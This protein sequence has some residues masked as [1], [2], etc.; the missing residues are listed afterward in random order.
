MDAFDAAWKKVKKKDQLARLKEQHAFMLTLMGVPRADMPK[1]SERKRPRSPASLHAALRA[2]L[3]LTDA[4]DINLQGRGRQQQSGGQ[5]AGIRMCAPLGRGT[6]CTAAVAANSAVDERVKA[7][8]AA[9]AGAEDSGSELSDLDDG[10]DAGG[11]ARAGDGGGGGDG[12]DTDSDGD[13]AMPEAREPS[14]RLQQRRQQAPAA[15]GKEEKKSVSISAAGVKRKAALDSAT[16]LTMLERKC[17]FD[18]LA[19]RVLRSSGGG[20]AGSGSDSASSGAPSS[21]GGTGRRAGK[22]RG[23]KRARLRSPRS[24]TRHEMDMSDQVGEGFNGRADAGNEDEAQGVDAVRITCRRCHCRRKVRRCAGTSGAAGKELRCAD[25]EG[26]TCDEP[27]D[28]CGEQECDDECLTL[29]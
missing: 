25:F 18:A 2:V 27:C 5:I 24:A 29:E 7:A 22:P 19:A 16:D 9:P 14:L 28:W 3:Q 6:L 12:S 26:T 4:G 10:E 15:S 21:G 11:A 8:A 20:E 23:N 17:A 1:F 13:L